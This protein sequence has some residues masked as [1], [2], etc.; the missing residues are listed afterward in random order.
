M[1]VSKSEST[2]ISLS[3]SQRMTTAIFAAVFGSFL[4]YFVA[5]AHSDVLH[6]AAHDTRHA[7]VAPCH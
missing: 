4:L 1:L 2:V 7:I 6:N 3:A 5:L